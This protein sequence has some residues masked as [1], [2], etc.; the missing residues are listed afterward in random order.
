[1]QIIVKGADFS[2]LGLGN[3][4]P[5][6]N[7]IV[8]AGITNETRKA[9]LRT[10]Y[11]S[12]INANL[13]EKFDV[14]N[15]FFNGTVLA[16]RLNLV[17]PLD[18][19]AAGRINF[20]NDLAANH[21]TSGYQPEGAN[22]R[23]GRQSKAIWSLQN[24][25]MHAYNITPEVGGSANKYLLAYNSNSATSKTFLSLQRNGSGLT[26]GAID[27]FTGFSTINVTQDVTKTGLLSIAR[28]GSDLKMY[29]GGVQIGAMTKTITPT[30]D[31]TERP[32]IGTIDANT[33]AVFTDAKLLFVG[34][35]SSSWTSTDEANLNSI[36]SAFRATLGI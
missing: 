26:K 7:Y 32:Y 12:L 34:H 1:M 18:N 15:L 4:S 19:D 20:I 24:F 9:A 3:V 21:T 35:G 31:G 17:N 10:M 23:Y 22:L 36:L 28:N 16:D 11:N 30:L 13:I 33:A 25:H 5:F 2:S 14:F 27:G 29:D 6:E 8:N